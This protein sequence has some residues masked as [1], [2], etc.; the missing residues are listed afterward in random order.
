MLQYDGELLVPKRYLVSP[1]EIDRTSGEYL[2]NGIRTFA[3]RQAIRHGYGYLYKYPVDTDI[4]IRHFMKK[5][6]TWIC[7]NIY[8]KIK[9][10]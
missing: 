1:P 5:S 10:I 4:V 9:L 6:D 8:L 2:K 3:C 7:F